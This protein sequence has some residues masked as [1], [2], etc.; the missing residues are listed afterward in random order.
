[1]KAISLGPCFIFKRNS[2]ELEGIQIIGVDDTCVVGSPKVLVPESKK[3]KYLT[4]N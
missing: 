3:L 2:T 1:M 4:I